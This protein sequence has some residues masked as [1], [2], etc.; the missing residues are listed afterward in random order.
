LILEK[1][2]E[3]K[4]SLNKKYYL[5]FF[6]AAIYSLAFSPTNLKILAYLSISLFYILLLE[7]DKKDSM[8]LS[9]L[10]GLISYLV[11]VSWVFNSIYDFGGQHFIS[12]ISITAI[13]VLTLAITFIPIGFFINKSLKL[14]SFSAC[15]FFSSLWILS[16]FI[17]SNIFGGFPWLILGHSQIH[18]IYENIY[19]ILGSYFVG[20]IVTALSSFCVVIYINNFKTKY[21]L[22]LILVISV[23]FIINII[24][25]NWTK[26]SD[27]KINFTIIQAN[28]HQG[29]KFDKSTI[30]KI[31]QKYEEMSNKYNGKDLIIWPETAIP[32]F[33]N[34]DLYLKKLQNKFDKSLLVSGI[35]RFDT[36]SNKIFNSIVF[37]NKNIQFYD[38]RHLV[39]F[40]E[41]MPFSN[42][43]QHV[44]K[45]LD[46]PMSN[47]SSG[48]YHQSSIKYNDELIYPLVCYEI[49][50]P[51]L[52]SVDKETYG[53]VINLSNDGWFGNSFAPYQHLQITQVRALETQ[54][55]IL[56]AANT[57]ISAIINPKGKIYK[58]IPL[59]K[60][61]VLSDT[62]YSTKFLT[63]YM[64]FGDYP[65]L[66]LIFIFIFLY[67][68][69]SSKHG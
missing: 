30:I 3:F 68:F 43:L 20:F 42:I 29:L 21:L 16:E 52:I 1:L 62:V 15:I 40:G 60:E 38:K 44:G 2:I 54:R 9:F 56:R 63:P 61:G 49:A 22:Q 6:A 28:V 17:R 65:V 13:F 59:N 57:G 25:I 10:Y 27:Q 55:Y 45:F 34:N 66:M 35:F 26:H 33:N 36:Q 50:F 24:P 4:S 46:V 58:S 8:R 32:T 7:S 18:T 41:Y 14:T 67:I 64:V 11:G 47:L 37:L 5:V 39:P 53:L 48:N 19:P 23:L 51:K 12:S 31:K 69:R